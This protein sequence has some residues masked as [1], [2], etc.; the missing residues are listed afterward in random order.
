MD[1]LLYFIWLA[2][3]EIANNFEQAMNG[4]NF[5]NEKSNLDII[6]AYTINFPWI[7]QQRRE[8]FA[9]TK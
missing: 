5:L 3:K 9:C 1:A 2:E 4:E 6:F 8:Y 7:I